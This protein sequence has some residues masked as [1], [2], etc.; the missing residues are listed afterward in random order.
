MESNTTSR[1]RSSQYF[2]IRS[3]MRVDIAN[4]LNDH[5]YLYHKDL[6]DLVFTS[7]DERLTDIICQEYVDSLGELLGEE[8][9]T[10]D[11]YSRKAIMRVLRQTGVLKDQ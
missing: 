8:L 10:Y 11:E 5:I 2:S 9:S 3:L 6:S 7:G 4:D 1:L